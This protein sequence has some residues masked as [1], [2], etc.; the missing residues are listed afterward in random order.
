MAKVL[1]TRKL[2]SSWVMSVRGHGL[3]ALGV[4]KLMGTADKLI[5]HH[6]AFYEGCQALHG[7]P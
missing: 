4:T 1:I 5:P 3:P 6:L 7:G 2:E